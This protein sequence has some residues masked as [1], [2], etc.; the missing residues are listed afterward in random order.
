MIVSGSKIG[1]VGRMVKHPPA[2]PEKLQQ[3]FYYC[4][5]RC[6]RV[7]VVVEQRSQNKTTAAMKYF[8]FETAPIAS[9]PVTTAVTRWIR[10]Q[11]AEIGLPA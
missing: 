8:N 2:S 10:R 4:E 3:L 6:M 7:N 9:S 5:Q 11:A 1:T